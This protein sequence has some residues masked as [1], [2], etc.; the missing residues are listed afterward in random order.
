MI[1]NGSAVRILT[2]GTLLLDATS[3]IQ[4]LPD[5]A[6]QASVMVGP[7]RLVKRSD[8]LLLMLIFI[9]IPIV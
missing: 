4:A 3:R 2:K 7:G 8:H 6:L 5:S 1:L 9:S